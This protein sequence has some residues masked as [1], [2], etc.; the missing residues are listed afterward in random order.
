MRGRTSLALQTAKRES[1]AIDGKTRALASLKN[2]QET[3]TSPQICVLLLQ[4]LQPPLDVICITY[5]ALGSPQLPAKLR[6]LTPHRVSTQR[7]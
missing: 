5:A 6:Y 3:L 2:Q 1:Q 4:R 7:Q